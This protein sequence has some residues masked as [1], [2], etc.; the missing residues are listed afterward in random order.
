MRRANRG[1]V[2]RKGFAEQLFRLG[3]IALGA[4][5]FREIVE[6]YGVF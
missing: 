6:L 2:N 5:N 4:Q 3:Q 1:R